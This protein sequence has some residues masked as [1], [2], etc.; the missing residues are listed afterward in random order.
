MRGGNQR[1]PVPS[2][3]LPGAPPP[4]VSLP[5][6]AR[7]FS[8]ADVRALCESL[9]APGV[10]PDGLPGSKASAVLVAVFEEAG[11]ARIIFTKR[12]DTMPNHQGDIVFPGGKFHLGVDE[13]L[14]HTALREAEEEI[15]LATAL[16]EIVAEL[17]SLPTVASRFVI[18][19]VVG[20]LDR[21]PDLVPHPREVA[22]VFDVAVSELLDEVTY[23]EERWVAGQSEMAMPF[24]ELEGET[25]WGATARILT[26]FLSDLTATRL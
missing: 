13:T 1:I 22:S 17:E 10:P 6:A 25:V 24:Y 23:R 7:M 18:T 12:P 21:R 8:L 9:P 19:P 5:H 20:L 3:S 16:V 2:A 11:E 4:W 15:G 26:G 14:H